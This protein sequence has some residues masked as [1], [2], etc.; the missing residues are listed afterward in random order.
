MS[1]QPP[2]VPSLVLAGLIVLAASPALAIDLNK[3]LA[4]YL[5]HFFNFTR[6]PEGHGLTASGGFANLCLLGD[7]QINPDIESID[8]QMAGDKTLRILRMTPSASFEQCHALFIDYRSASLREGILARTRGSPTLT[9]STAPGFAA[10]GG[11]VEFAR[12]DDRLRM[13]INTRAMR[14]QQ[15]KISSKLLNL[16]E[17]V[18]P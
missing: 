16:A 6:W 10:A 17:I 15:L 1:L 14:D 9:L 4:A 8:G 7:T 12:V 18:T 2:R 3:A 13:K 5:Y 11:V